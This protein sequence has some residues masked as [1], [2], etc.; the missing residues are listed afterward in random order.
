[1]KVNSFCLTCLIQMQEAQIRKF[2]D[3]EKKMKHMREVLAFLAS[4]DADLSSPALVKPLSKIYEKYWG[5]KDAMADVKKEFNE[6]LLR[7]EEDVEERI[8]MHKDP[9]EAALSYART[10]NYIDYAA[11][12]DISKETLLEL[13]E[14]QGAMGLDQK[15]YRRLKEDLEKAKT[16]IYLTDNCGEVVLDK[17]ALRIL[18]EQY[19]NLQ[20]TAIVRGAPVVN[21]ADM[22]AA[23]AVGL[24][25]VVRVIGNGSDIAGT[26]L[27]YVSQDVKEEIQS[28][29]VILAKGQ[30]NFETLHGCGLNIYYLLLCKCEWFMRRF[31]AEKFEGIL[32][33]EQRFE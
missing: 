30:G 8:R 12:K 4:E 13:F 2:D 18:K 22:E 25:K 29:D 31:Q 21:D 1:M 5:T 32:A 9:L 3:E 7:M 15:E 28:A 6:F 10:G 14:K 20:V 24:D 33:N 11:V 23:I 16:L 19:P 27:D 26:D 17:I